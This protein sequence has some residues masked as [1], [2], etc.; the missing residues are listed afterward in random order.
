MVLSLNVLTSI[1]C[2]TH[3]MNVIKNHMVEVVLGGILI[4]F[5]IYLHPILF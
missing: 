1:V 2:V 4:W 5:Y 3:G